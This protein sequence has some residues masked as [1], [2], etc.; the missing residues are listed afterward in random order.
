M[1]TSS[2]DK[3]LAYKGAIHDFPLPNSGKRSS[4]LIDTFAR[5]ANRDRCP[6]SSLDI[7]RPFEPLC[8]T[9]EELL[10]AMSGG[11]R[12]GIDAPY[13]PR[14]CDMR[15]YDRGEIC[16]IVSRFEKILFVGDS[17][18][19]HAVGA[20]HILL[21]EDLGY[22]GVTQWNFRLDEKET[23][24]CNGQFDTLKCGVQGIFNSD[25]VAKFDLQSLKCDARR[26][27]IQNHVMTTYPPTSAELANL[28]D[29]ISNRA[30][31]ETRP[32]AFIYSQGHHNDLDV[33]A[34]S[35]WLTSIQRSISERLPRS[36]KRA[37]LFVTPGAAGPNMIDQDL[38][39]HGVK[40]LHLFETSMREL[41]PQK[42][43]DVLGVWNATVQTTLDDGK[44]SGIRGN[45][46]KIMMILNWLDK[47]SPAL[48]SSSK[49]DSF[50]P[51]NS[52]AN[53]KVVSAGDDLSA[54]NENVAA[55]KPSAPAAEMVKKVPKK[56]NNGDA[57]PAIV[58]PAASGP[59]TAQ[60][61][62]AIPVAAQEHDRSSSEKIQP[63]AHKQ[64]G[65]TTPQSHPDQT[66]RN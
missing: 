32:I 47:A 26:L 16:S 55:E 29:A 65:P 58:D 59:V 11:G 14:G 44:H 30:E 66:A 49:L 15:W 37:Q 34:T 31:E 42:D 41:G 52:G 62:D 54:R 19:R 25:D 56:A 53:G 23:C 35:G 8:S 60:R 7:H 4:D 21:R 3:G 40:A 43:V 17:M 38:L 18:M 51:S 20:L 33:Q 63:A 13:M 36:V 45:L 28:G 27:N 5:F 64:Q 61:A 2:L 50:L 48:D 24:F 46:L 57:R 22:G 1:R 12:I 39:H 10:E 6:I 9:K